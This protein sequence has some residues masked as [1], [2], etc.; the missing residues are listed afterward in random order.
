M[1]AQE[2]EHLVLR[3]AGER[4]LW[5]VVRAYRYR[6][7]GYVVHRAIGP[8]IV[9]AG[10]PSVLHI[11]VNGGERR[12]ED[13]CNHRGAGYEGRGGG[14]PPRCHRPAGPHAAHH[15]Y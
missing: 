1:A 4:A 15:R 14:V 3:A 12:G 9:A 5:P 2:D 7:N 10:V 11:S 8:Y 6:Y 13:D